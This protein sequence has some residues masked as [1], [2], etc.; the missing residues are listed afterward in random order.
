CSICGK[1]LNEDSPHFGMCL[2]CYLKENPLF[3]LPKTFNVNVCIDCGSYS[4]K[5]TWIEP[6]ADDLFSILHE[7]IQKFLLKSLLKNKKVEISFSTNEDTITYTSTNLIKSIEVLIMGRLRESPNIHHQQEVKLNLNQ[8]LCRNCSNLRGGTY[9]TS[10]IQLRVKDGNQIELVEKVLVEIN[11]FVNNIFDRDHR[12]YLSKIKDQKYGVDLYLST[13]ELMNHIIKFLKG[14]HQ[15]LLK[16]SKKLV[17][18][19]IQKGKNLYRLKSLIKFLPVVQ[20]DLIQIDN[21]EFIVENITKNKIILKS[22][23]NVKLIKDYSY[24]FNENIIKKR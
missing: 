19:D 10:I 14:K 13:N 16:R 22:K 21:R 7:I 11:K 8:M 17:G 2:K 6:N 1:S 5:D 4:K 9:F 12:H 18:R 24:F 15:F 3:E 23:N 20:N